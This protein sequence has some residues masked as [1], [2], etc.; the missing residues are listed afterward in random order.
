M[1][2]VG[3]KVVFH[4]AFKSK[5]EAV[6]HERRGQFIIGRRIEGHKR[7]VLLSRKKS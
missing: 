3:E 7:F 5:R 4:G 6:K 1:A 2:K